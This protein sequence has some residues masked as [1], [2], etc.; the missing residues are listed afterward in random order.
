M[1]GSRGVKPLRPEC[2]LAS[3]FWEV[4]GAERNH[5]V[6]SSSCGVGLQPLITGFIDETLLDNLR[7]FKKGYLSTRF[8]EKKTEGHQ[9]SIDLHNTSHQGVPSD[10]SHTRKS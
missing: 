5:A 2:A 4:C 8:S 6:L 7:C 9:L 10:L 3:L 1:R